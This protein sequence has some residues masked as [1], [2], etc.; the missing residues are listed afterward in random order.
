MHRIRKRA[1][2]LVRLA[3]L[4]ARGGSRRLRRLWRYH[5]RL[6]A[7]EPSYRQILR[8]AATLL[9]EL[10]ALPRLVTVALLAAVEHLTTTRSFVTPALTH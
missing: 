4:A 1:R 9:L 6:L 10:A 7:T 2:R 3:R 8:A 5:Q